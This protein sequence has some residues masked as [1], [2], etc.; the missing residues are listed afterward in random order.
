[1]PKR[2]VCA[3]RVVQ[4]RRL[5]AA[6]RGSPPQKRQKAPFLDG[7]PLVLHLNEPAPL[8]LLQIIYDTVRH[9]FEYADPKRKMAEIRVRHF[10]RVRKI[11]L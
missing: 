6:T 2:A 8:F 5:G 10:F 1:M 3:F 7:E 4:L 11:L 9:M